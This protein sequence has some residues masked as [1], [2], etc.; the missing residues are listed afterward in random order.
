MV[1][2]FVKKQGLILCVCVCIVSNLDCMD[3]KLLQMCTL[4][5][6]TQT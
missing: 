3:L 4:H 6:H 1:E 5:T 2:S